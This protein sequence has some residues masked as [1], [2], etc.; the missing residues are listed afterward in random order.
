MKQCGSS[1]D[2]GTFY[3]AAF[4]KSCEESRTGLAAVI[5][6]H[7]EAARTVKRD[8]FQAVDTAKIRRN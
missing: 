5:I 6:L 3:S 4:A 1:E 2:S 7:A 8:T